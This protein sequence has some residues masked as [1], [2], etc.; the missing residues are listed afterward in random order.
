M[1]GWVK[2]HRNF[3]EWEWYTSSNHVKLF[4][5]ILLRC[6]YKES[7]WR[8]RDIKPG[9]LLYG[10]KKL[11]EWAGLSEQNVRTILKDLKSTN[12]VTIESNR[13]YSI[14]T[15]SNWI[16]YQDTNQPANQQLTN[17]QPTGNHIQEYK[18]DKKDKKDKLGTYKNILLSSKQY[19][20]LVQRYNKSLVEKIIEAMSEWSAMNGKTYK[21][22]NAAIHKWI[23]DKHPEQA[24]T[25]S[26]LGAKPV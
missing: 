25:N 7:K 26:K 23:R 11:A 3:I 14:I 9:Q 6:N 8:G 5:T 12:E 22:Y 2:L 1:D 19:S 17:S 13:Q 15:V 20:L 4:I 10:R 21:D 18:K 16:K 24:K